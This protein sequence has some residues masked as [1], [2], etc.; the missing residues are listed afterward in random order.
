MAERT[1][2]FWAQKRVR[3]AAALVSLP[4]IAGVVEACGGGGAQETYTTGQL[5]QTAEALTPA[6]GTPDSLKEKARRLISECFPNYPNVTTPGDQ[7]ACREIGYGIPC[8]YG[9][10][11]AEFEECV[12]GKV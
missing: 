3:I 12:S 10:P 4:A 1:P 7:N 8:L 6:T 5:A 9:I 2:N 11:P